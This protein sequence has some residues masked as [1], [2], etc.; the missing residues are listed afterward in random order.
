MVLRSRLGQDAG[1][2]NLTGEAFLF[3]L[4]GTLRPVFTYVM[5]FPVTVQEIFGGQ[6]VHA[7]CSGGQNMR[8]PTE[9]PPSATVFL[10]LFFLFCTPPLPHYAN[11][12]AHM[13]AHV[14]TARGSET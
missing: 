9:R 3:L 7:K 10:F 11:T 5:R 13:H 2:S 8:K 1:D 12:H 14:R 4:L 6:I